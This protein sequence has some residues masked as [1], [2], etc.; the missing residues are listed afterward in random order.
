MRGVLLQLHGE[1][2]PANSWRGADRAKSNVPAAVLNVKV[3]L[4][5]KANERR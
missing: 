3:H 2:C 1:W 5:A 4:D